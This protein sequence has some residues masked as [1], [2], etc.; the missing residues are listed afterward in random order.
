[1]SLVE[2][3]KYI[4]NEQ[5]VARPGSSGTKGQLAIGKA[6]VTDNKKGRHILNSIG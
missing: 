2:T 1:M 5:E 3:Y 6:I 4:T